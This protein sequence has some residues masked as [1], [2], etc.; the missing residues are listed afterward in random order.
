M[1]IEGALEYFVVEKPLN[2]AAFIYKCEQGP[3]ALVFA[4]Y[5]DSWRFCKL[6][7]LG[8]QGSIGALVQC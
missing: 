5:L 4:V 6:N 2:S 8:T 3:V 7:T 1:K